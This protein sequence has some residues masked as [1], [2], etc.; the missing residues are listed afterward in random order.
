MYNSKYS[1][2]G[3]N[4]FSFQRAQCIVSSFW[5]VFR[6]NTSSKHTLLETDTGPFIVG[7]SV[8]TLSLSFSKLKWPS[9]YF[10]NKEL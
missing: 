1:S 8:Q 2:L 9:Q 10:F 7:T 5:L 4:S 3:I 6:S